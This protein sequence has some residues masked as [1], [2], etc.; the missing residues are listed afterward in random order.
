MTR[1]RAKARAFG[2]VAP[3]GIDPSISGSFVAGRPSDP[4]SEA[5][6]KQRLRQ[7]L[8]GEQQP[9]AGRYRLMRRIG[10]GGSGEVFEAWDQQLQRRV[11]I[12]LLR[13]AMNGGLDERAR[14][15]TR[16][17]QA[18]ARLAH[19]NIV[20]VFDVGRCSPKM[21]GLL[22]DEPEGTVFVV[23]EYV[24]GLTLG[25][26]LTSASRSWR[27]VVAMFLVAA[28]ALAAAHAQGIVHRDFKP[29]NAVIGSD[30]RLR[31]LDF[32]LARE[33][34][35]AAASPEDTGPAP[36]TVEMAEVVERASS[37]VLAKVTASGAVMG[38]PSYMAPEQHRGESADAQTDQYSFCV[39]LWFGLF[40]EYPFE[41][42][43]LG[44]LVVAK[45]GQPPTPPAKRP[46]WLV[47][48]LRVGLSPTRSGR[49]A[50][51]DRVCSRLERG[52][53]RRSR[54]MAMGVVGVITIAGIGAGTQARV[55]HDRE[56]CE[57]VT[58]VGGWQARRAHIRSL[59]AR[60]ADLRHQADVDR[61][62]Q[63]LDAYAERLQ[64]EIQASCDDPGAPGATAW[65]ECLRGREQELEALVTVLAEADAE[66]LARATELV[67]RLPSVVACSDDG[68]PSRSPGV[69]DPEQTQAL[70]RGE[71]L[72]K[73][74]HHARAREIAQGLLAPGD[75]GTRARAHMLLGTVNLLE[76]GRTPPEA[77]EQFHAALLEAERV[78]DSATAIRAL[79]QLV[80]VVGAVEGQFRQADRY[81]ALA[82]AKLERHE[83]MVELR[84][85]LAFQR[86]LSRYR[87]YRNDAALEQYG[88][89][90]QLRLASLGP[91]HPKTARVRIE[92]GH[93]LLRQG[94]L[95]RA[96][97]QHGQALAILE[98][99]YGAEH[100]AV[101]GAL[102]G[103]AN[104]DSK[105]Q[106]LVQALAK[107]DRVLALNRA[108]RGERHDTVAVALSNRAT[109]L[110]KLERYEAAFA[111]IDQALQLRLELL[112]P[113]NIAVARTRSNR[114]SLLWKLGRHEE[115]IT[116]YR[117]AHESFSAALGPQHPTVAVPLV[118][119]GNLLMARGELEAAL[120]PLTEALHIMENGDA[121]A[122]DGLAKVLG[123][124]GQVHLL[125][126]HH[127]Q[128]RVMLERAL[129][130][131]SS[132]EMRQALSELLAGLGREEGR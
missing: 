97:A 53:G 131:A 29:S 30:G 68:A 83:G 114:A 14:R 120:V 46:R 13:G 98:R 127:E 38:T 107:F 74:G 1:V 80:H 40:G 33:I 31:L 79:T 23:M 8:F 85:G 77:T 109:V 116:E 124:L 64:R 117:R 4:A 11:A 75:P 24:E 44:E 112:G 129:S 125:A 42:D 28:R 108:T 16:E 55:I 12:K 36:V 95:E 89:A 3:A 50:S 132:S 51:M 47:R 103:L 93:V 27:E 110:E 101:A 81:A 67:A 61:V 105:Q 65:R 96:R 9:R 45:E 73:V 94:K 15:L 86:G 63:G 71:M 113:D 69:A 90:L 128:A 25:A 39:A 10:A 48:T 102:V 126:G 106:R 92:I 70:L 57:G 6:A 99:Y 119:L 19:P 52:L 123:T 59:R 100:I 82:Q 91:Q 5:R 56:A 17:A 21:G 88:E 7:H 130:E 60:S 20:T 72:A 22:G 58:D 62:E 66:V 32:G 2:R 43:S 111:S 76:T 104:I 54:A 18:L 121:V 37:H 115:A 84:A 78:G 34:D 35:G 41:G 26:W 122:T 87:E 118:N 49:H